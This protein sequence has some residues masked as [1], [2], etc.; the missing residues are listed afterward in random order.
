MKRIIKYILVLVLCL[1]CGVSIIGCGKADDKLSIYMPDGA[2]ALA[3]SKLMHENKTFDRDT[4]YT[5][6]AASNISNY[7]LNKT[8][9]IAIMPINMASKIIDNGASYKI[10]A[11]VTNGNLYIVGSEDIS[12]LSH[13]VGSVVGVIGKS[14]VPDLNLRYL[15]T[16]AGIPFEEGEAAVEGK[17]VLRYFNDASVLLPMLKTNKLKFGLLPEP[18]VSKLLNMATNFHIELNIQALWEGGSYPQA[19]MVVKTSLASDKDFV[20]SI[21]NEMKTVESW[22]IENPTQAVDAVKSHLV[23]G[24]TTSIDNI[25]ATAI[26]NSNIKIYDTSSATEVARMKS[27]LEKIRTIAPSAIGN[28]TDDIF[29]E[30]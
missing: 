14:N 19:V 20:R 18:A 9:D 6:V 22:V 25:S 1:F 12:N 17:V 28:Y 3:M 24:L 7:I 30:L 23:E 8:A 15:L 13:L 2:P 4:E 26:T 11:T 29:C 16:E 10:C 21:I 27:Y 5:V